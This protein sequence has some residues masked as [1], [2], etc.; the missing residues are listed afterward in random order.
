M[1]VIEMFQDGPTLAKGRWVVE[2][3]NAAVYMLSNQET[4]PW[5][6]HLNYFDRAKNKLG[7]MIGTLGFGDA[8]MLTPVL[9]EHKR[10]NPDWEIHLACDFPKRQVFSGLPYIDGFIDYPVPESTMLKFGAV[11]FTEYSSEFNPEARK[12]HMTDQFAHHLGFSKDEWTENKKPDLRLSEDE[13]DWAFSTFARTKGKRRLGIQVSAGNRNR[14]YPFSRLGPELDKMIRDGWEIALLGSPGEFRVESKPNGMLDLT[15]HGLTWRQSVAFMTT[16]DCILA[17]D[18]SLMH[19]AGTLD[20]PCVALFGPFPFDL[21]TRYYTS[22]FA[23]RGN[24]GCKMAP[25]FHNF[26]TGL[27]VFPPGGPCNE[28]GLCNE[29]T[30]IEPARVRA[31]IEQIAR[32]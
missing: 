7:L 9:R 8:L 5:V 20:I 14:T 2:D 28:T 27:P 30:S 13:R 17:P 16:C 12:R 21:R 31:K 11:Y 6:D 15:R 32:R 25:C 3:Q 18:S 19:A 22:V 26:H 10:L 23:L 24:G 4:K 29:L 1:H